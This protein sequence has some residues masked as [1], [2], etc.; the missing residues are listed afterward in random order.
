MTTKQHAQRKL[1]AAEKATT[2][3][4][5]GKNGA[6]NALTHDTVNGYGIL[7][8]PQTTRRQL[9]QARVL[10]QADIAMLVATDWPTDS[11]YDHF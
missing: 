7:R 1:T 11:D 10:I 9:E 5:E 6:I 2:L 3:V 4:L 8:D